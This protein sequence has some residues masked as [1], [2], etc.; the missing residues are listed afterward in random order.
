M[1]I[2]L[3]MQ[4]WSRTK[5]QLR[6]SPALFSASIPLLWKFRAKKTA[7]NVLAYTVNAKHERAINKQYKE[8]NR[9]IN[10]IVA[11][12]SSKF[13]IQIAEKKFLLATKDPHK[14]NH[15]RILIVY[16]GGRN[17]FHGSKEEANAVTI[18]RVI[19]SGD[20]V[21]S[22]FVARVPRSCGLLLA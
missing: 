2:K 8:N 5:T 18:S 3:R 4:R 17:S 20:R 11:T 19:S 7:D 21:T 10:N 22:S 1:W 6:Y 12:C 13:E 14:V 9:W 16:S 15:R